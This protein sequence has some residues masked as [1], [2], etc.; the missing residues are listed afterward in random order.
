MKMNRLGAL[1]LTLAAALGLALLAGRP[2][3]PRPAEAPPEAFSAIRAL[4]DV[5]VIARTP[6]PVGSP[7]NA[8]VR[9]YVVLRMNALGLSPQVRPDFGF[10]RIDRI[11]EPVFLGGA[12]ENIV[13]VLPG[14]DRSAPA[15]AIMAHYD[16]VPSSPGAADDAAGVA[17]A[18]EVARIL[19]AGGPPA[20]DVIFVITDGEE[21]G[22]LGAQAFFAGDPLARRVG[23]LINMEAR[24]GGGLVQM[25][26]TGKRNQGTIDLLKAEARR[27]SSS[28][29]AVLLYSAMPNDT[30]F[31]VSRGAGV[32][33][34]NFA[35][36][37]R[38]FDYHAASST[39][40]NLDPG[41]LQHMGDQVIAVAQSVARSPS[42]PAEGPDQVFSH[43]A[44]DLIVAYPAVAG[45][46]VL[47]AAAGLLALAVRNARRLGALDAPGVVRGAGAGIYLLLLTGALLHLA[48]RIAAGGSG[49][50]EQRALLARADLWEVALL[51]VGL[52]GLLL[53]P[54][55]ASRGRSRLQACALGLAAGAA[56]LA[57]GWD[58]P[59]VALGVAAAITGVMTFG[60]PV[61]VAPAWTG[62]LLTA[63]AAAA[64]L[65][66][67]APTA[68]FLVAWPLL[69]ACLLALATDLGA[70]SPR[71]RLPL[72]GVLIGTPVTA[73]ILGYAHGVFLGLDLPALLAAFAW[74][75][76][77]TLW[78]L[79]HGEREDPPGD[80]RIAL[81]AAGGLAGALAIAAFLRLVPPWSERHPEVTLVQHLQDAN[82]GQAFLVSPEPRLSR[83]SRAVLTRDGGKP[84][85]ARDDLVARGA[86]WSVPAPAV[87]LTGV[88][89][90]LEA[91][92]DGRRRLVLRTPAGARG[93][94]LDLRSNTLATGATVNGRPAALL[95]APGVWN[96]IRL[97][98]P[99]REIVIEFRPVGPG[100]LEA[101]TLTRLSGWP[102]GLAPLPPRRPSER[103]F[104]DSD[105]ALVKAGRTFNW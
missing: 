89:S 22:L 56:A 26:Q 65:Q 102:A 47:A 50:L 105:T 55:L 30:D 37:G 43:V 4:A 19:R 16:S 31:T 40:A 39:P 36:I 79:A 34:L 21:A 101:R 95:A 85:K 24:G 97:Q 82:T 81:V 61:R 94:S 14:R 29:L 87:T 38:Q 33:G 7:E 49:F 3:A 84:A 73:W 42:L 99:P 77:L 91:L 96:R 60:P 53:A 25:F 76:G 17:T 20:R 71:W 78:P 51:L 83:W 80:A 92:P 1:C 68:A 58:L 90:T 70:A 13:G 44:G 32:A 48:R 46:L 8:Q 69:A 62:V 63:L 12:V 67:L 57:F 64:I 74:L 66:V 18:L 103:P 15:L 27:P 23:F 35:F 72:A 86:Y 11:Q 93:L 52:A 6:H 5:G 45:W 10:R 9:D 104:G 88:D 98:A 100:T 2:P 75:A 28:S 41:S 54:R 59:A